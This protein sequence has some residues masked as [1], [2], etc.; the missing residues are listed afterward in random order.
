MNDETLRPLRIAVGIATAGRPEIL[1]AALV[2][3]SRQ[4]RP[5]DRIILCAPGAADVENLDAAGLEIALGRRGLTCQRN[6]ILA[7]ARDC[8][9]IAFFDDDFFPAAE[10]LAEV[11]QVFARHGDVVMATGLLIADGIIGPGIEVAEAQ[12]LLAADTGIHGGDGIVDV[13]NAYGCNF[14][15]RVAPVL[16][17]RFAFDENLPLY[18]WLEDIDFSRQL[19]PYGRIVKVAA[20]RGIHLGIKRARQS[21]RRLGYSQI[22]NPIYL[23]RK[24]TCA[25]SRA[26]RLMGRNV[27]ANC[28]R[29]LRPEP[30]I[31]RRGRVLGNVRGMTDLLAGRLHPM[32][33]L[34]L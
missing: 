13:Y 18:G 12:R 29:L 3:Q 30:Y 20:A 32:R 16:Q 5:A 15:V 19:A 7:T 9:V 1:R 11:E 14:A 4:T 17:N 28:L 22:A 34:N 8:D 21:G 23:S 33:V 24:G 25:W 27:T 26:L 10:Y 31:D 2:Q 6:E